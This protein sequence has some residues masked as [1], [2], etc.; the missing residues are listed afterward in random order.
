MAAKRGSILF[1]IIIFVTALLL[2]VT[3]V[4]SYFFIT[5]QKKSLENE[6]KLRGLSL[7]KNLSNS[8]SDGILTKDELSVSRILADTMNNKGLIYIDVVNKQNLIVGSNNLELTGSE[9]KAPQDIIQEKDAEGMV[10]YAA[11]DGAKIMDFSSP[12]LAKGMIKIATAHL[13]ISYGLIEAVLYD[14]YRN[15]AIISLLSLILGVAG[16][17]FLGITITTPLKTV[18]RGAKIIGTGDLSHRIQVKS[19]NEIGT[20]ATIINMMTKDLKNSQELV[21]K[22]EIMDRDIEVAR[23]IQLALLPKK[24]LAVP[25]FEVGKYYMPTKE[26]GGDYYDIKYLA[27][28]KYAFMVA[29]VSGKGVPAA[30][31]MA[32]LKSIVDSEASPSVESHV[33]MKRINERLFPDLKGDMF[34]TAFYCVMDTDASVLDISSAGHTGGL[35]FRA[36]TGDVMFYNPRGIPIGTDPGPKF[37]NIIKN[38]H[39]TLSGGDVIVVFTDGITE[40]MNADHVQYNMK[41]L[42]SAIKSSCTRSAENITEYIVNDVKKFAG[43]AEQSD[44]IALLVLKKTLN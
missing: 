21:V 1:E 37:N 23:Q 18:T 31:V 9:Y 17:C 44:D 24:M 38:D 39:V 28:N 42:I 14:M 11:Q 29:D 26:V 36:A 15:A 10:I 41:R 35:V 4:M 19:G 20:L 16:A 25:G 8:I 2:V 30:L 5:Q 7:V 22:Q 12:V 6:I 43:K 3:S 33:T 27:E 40:A 34:I 32:M 13:G